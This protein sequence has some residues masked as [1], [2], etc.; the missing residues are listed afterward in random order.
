[1]SWSG[2][3]LTWAPV[4]GW[5]AVA[6]VAAALLVLTLWHPLAVQ[7][8]PRR[9][10]VLQAL[11]LAVVVLLLLALLRPTL[12]Y[13]TTRRQSSTLVLLVD[14]SRSMQ[15]TD[16]A[17]GQSRWQFLKQVFQ[18]AE[19]ELRR[20]AEMLDVELYLFDATV[21]PGSLEN[22]KAE[23]PLEAS[24]E[25]TALGA[26]L[27]DV[28]RRDAGKRLAGVVLLSDGAQRAVPP[29]DEPPQSAARRL[30]D[31]DYPLFTIC[32]G[33]G[34][35]PDQNRDLALEGLQVVGQQ[36]YVK[37]R[38]TA[39]AT[40]RVAGY[41]NQPLAVEL[42]W[43]QSPGQMTVVDRQTVQATS[44]G[45]A[46]PVELG[47]VP[48]IPGEF[49]LALRVAPQ[50]DE[51]VVTNNELATFVTVLKGGLSVLYVEGDLQRVEKRFLRAALDG[52][53]TLR[54]DYLYIDAQ[55]PETRPADL[56]ERF[57]PGKYDVYL[58]G[59]VDHTAFTPEE[60][61]TLAATVKAGAGLMMLGGFHSFGPGGYQQT[62][63]DEILP[64]AMDPLERQPFGEPAASD[65]HLEGPLPMRPTAL[66]QQHF[67]L[68]LAP[69]DQNQQLWSELTPLD[70][71]NRFR[72]LK[73]RANVLAEDPQGR[74]LLVAQ[75]VGLGRVLAFA[76]DSTWRWV[77]DGH[78]A[79][80]QRF[81]R[82]IVLWL[83]RKDQSNEGD[84]WLDVDPRRYS[85]GQRVE[86][87]A[88]ARMADGSAIAQAN[89][90]AEIVDPSGQTHTV[91]LQH[92]AD[93]AQG[94]WLDTAVPGD[95]TLRVTARQGDQQLGSA[96]ARFLVYAQD[97]ELENPAADPAL[98]ASMAEVTQGESLPPE[99]LASLFQRLL[100]QPPP[101]EVQTQARSTL[102][103]T[104]WLFL[105][106]T[107]LLSWEWALRKRWG[108]V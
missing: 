62:P 79:A 57:E 103:D 48:Q 75:D 15:I 31:L 74:P 58:L 68:L 105:L 88:G 1:M 24:G 18:Q 92:H 3:E 56:R 40:V 65:L 108:L 20:L 8:A 55:T 21:E 77:M 70:G 100:D 25:A 30:A 6:A 49:K 102:W 64:I 99:Q 42:L 94:A 107:L 78:G 59:D 83:A 67:V 34:R 98:L 5:A 7:A 28:L 26:A 80:H 71:G 97:L 51:A 44:D 13:T 35:G 12:L 17:A 14:R 73:P 52:S 41:L 50:S 16:M 45:Q 10:R 93:Y 89:L 32:F 39:R 4:G 61:T 91:R 54:L 38:L 27:D 53:P 66:G 90:E 104:W 33:Q 81:W 2:W 43:E 37:N 85:S 86:F 87:L 76:G 36:V 69:P 46:L 11:R 101:L 9:K 22:G 47:Y 96:Q 82:Q 19:P 29:R 84:V 23:L 72:G 63:L 106:L 60:L 95:Y